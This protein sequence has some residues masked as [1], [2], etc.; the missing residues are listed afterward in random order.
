LLQGGPGPDGVR[1]TE[2]GHLEEALGMLRHI[3][4]L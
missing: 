3:A 1:V 2:V 4:D